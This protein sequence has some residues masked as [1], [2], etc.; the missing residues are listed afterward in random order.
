MKS[1][2]C[3]AVLATVSFLSF[4]CG[5][6]EPTNEDVLKNYKPEASNNPNVPV[7]DGANKE[8]GAKGKPTK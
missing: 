6:A 2:L 7:T 3:V 8:F 4:G 5:T 1:L